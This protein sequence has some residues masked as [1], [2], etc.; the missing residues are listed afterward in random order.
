M[1]HSA[2]DGP[3]AP[4]ADGCLPIAMIGRMSLLLD[5]F[6][7]SDRLTLAQIA[8][9]TGLPRSSTHRLLDQL[10]ALHW[11]H[12]DGRGYELGTRLIELGHR[13]KHQNR[14]HQA[15]MPF[16]WDLHRAT[17]FVVHLAILDGNDVVYLEKVGDR[18]AA[19]I[20]TRVGSRQPAHCTAVGKAILA[21]SPHDPHCDDDGAELCRKTN[22]SITSPVALRATLAEIRERG[23]AVDRGEC[24]PRI[25]CLAAPIGPADETIAAVSVCGPLDRMQFDHRLAAP[26]RLTALQIWRNHAQT[27]LRAHP[28]LQHARV[29]AGPAMRDVS[30]NLGASRC[31]DSAR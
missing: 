6:D 5:A 28:T 27:Q 16:L 19:S 9:R 11:L 22:Y 13:A 31:V 3:A 26:V 10:V 24:I 2:L 29:P 21:T 18:L 8:R 4:A 14:V 1:Q 17:G 25:G 20:P 23:I 7:G 30:P 15:A 12:R